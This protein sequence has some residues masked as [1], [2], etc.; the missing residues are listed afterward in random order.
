MKKP[1]QNITADYHQLKSISSILISSRLKT[2]V[3]TLACHGFIL[4]M[5]VCFNGLV[6]VNKAF[7]NKTQVTAISVGTQTGTATYGTAAPAITYVITLT[8]GTTGGTQANDAISIAWTSSTPAGVNAVFSSGASYNPASFT[9][10]TLTISTTASTLAGSYPFTITNID[11]NGGGTKTSTGTLTVGKKA[12]TITGV[13]AS[14]KV[15]DGNT[16]ATVSGTAT[17]NGAI[18]SDVVT[19]GGA[20]VGTF[21]SANVGSRTVTVTGY[22]ISGASAGNYTLTQPSLTANITAAPLTIT[23]STQSKTYGTTLTS[24]TG[25]TTFTSS[26]LIGGQTIGSVTITYG[27]GGTGTSAVGT[28]TGQATPSAATGGTFSASNYNITYVAGDLVVNAASLTITAAN[29]SMT[30]GSSI[31][32]LTAT[33]SGFVNGDTQATIVT[34]SATLSTSASSTSNVGTYSISTSGA[35]LNNSNYTISYVSG[36]LTITAAT[37]TVSADNQYKVQG[38]ANPTFTVSYSGFVNS[39]SQAS[40]VTTG[41]TVSTTA[42]TGSPAGSYA[43]TPSG[44]VL[45][46]SNYT[47]SYINGTLTIYAASYDWTGAAGT[48]D[49]TNPGNWAVSGITAT[50]YPGSGTADAVNI[51]VS[52]SYT[53]IANF[54]VLSS[55]LPNSIALLTIGSNGGASS[56]TITG[57]TLTV[58]GTMTVNS[59]ANFSVPGSGSLAIN[60]DF[61]NNGTI[62]FGSG[63]V[64]FGNNFYN[65]AGGVISFGTGLVTFSSTSG[66]SSGPTL[67]KSA[68]SSTNAPVTFV[69]LKLGDNGH[70]QFKSTIGTGNAA[71]FCLATNGI[72]TIGSSTVVNVS[73]SGFTL[74]SNANSSAAVD[75]IPSSSNLNGTF[76]VQRF[77]TGGNNS[78]YRCYRMLTSPVYTTTSG[79]SKILS[80]A[81]LNASATV[82]ATT[83][84]GAFTG[85][86]GTGF[87]VYNVNPTIYL[88]NESLAIDNAY[89]VSGKHVGIASITGNTV[90][91]ISNA[92]GT[93]VYTSGVSIPV[94][95]GYILYFVGPNTRTSGTSSIP[96]ADATLTATGSLNQGDVTVNLWYTPSGGTAGQLSYT[97]SLPGPGYNMVGNPYASTID[98]YSV[99]SYNYNSGTNSGID[100]IYTLSPT[101]PSQTY[102]VYTIAGSSSPSAYFAVSGQGFIVHATGTGQTLTFKEANKSP[103]KQ[104]TG[105]QLMMGTPVQGPSLTGLYLKLEKDSL[106]YDYTGIYFGNNWSDTFEIGDALYFNGNAI[107]IASFSSDGKMAA[108]NHLHTYTNDNRVR[109]YTSTQSDGAYTLKIEGIRNIDTTYDIYLVDHYKKDSVNIRKTGA[110]VFNIL[111]S[112]T[113]SFGGYR[114]ELAIHRNPAYAYQLLDFTAQQIAHSPHVLLTWKT[115]NELDN[116]FTVERSNDG[117]ATFTIAGGL[118]GTGAGLYSLTDK[119]AMDGQ[120]LY[121]LKSEDINNNVTYSQ[122][123]EVM[124]SGNGNAD[125]IRLYPNPATSAINLNVLGKTNG[126]ASYSITVSNSTG[127]IVK[128]ATS[129][130]PNWQASV[131]DL[132]PGTY[133]VR[134]VDNQTQSFVGESKFIK[135]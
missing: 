111:K 44:A 34:T 135:L 56:L 107:N 117:G 126:T 59:G 115:Q 61:T 26:G 31:P 121:R 49:W 2:G 38:S 9:T 55:T 12:L 24:A 27:T 81:Y 43:L 82:G 63:A 33:Y 104:L 13:T 120:N 131:S 84:Y 109:L 5:A 39:D 6:C 65:N 99:F 54:P 72:L 37:L 41:A 102:N 122:I 134:V 1:I 67:I 103:T 17:L 108:V 51:G 88:Y 19:L 132:L 89:Y 80:L 47:I 124:I 87:T 86:A 85:G 58:S 113:A 70:F 7:A 123:V 90:T 15:Y 22:T 30:Y 8:R 75:V 133:V 11:G 98:L 106:H 18:G 62:T 79:S 42:T 64:T 127:F 73:N 36:T 29:Q 94:G 21:S 69:N 57:T 3:K 83:Y 110:Y 35:V 53:S 93:V 74:L 92:T 105:G 129:S 48:S 77:I 112:D 128:Q 23:A 4:L 100:A 97:S 118:H 40:I 114:F 14:D 68:P 76:Y 71:V 45:N 91:T 78:M 20:P 28:Y 60:K 32:T 116:N 101:G 125:K 66:T 119:N 25:I 130:Q 50:S 16:T 10:I 96:P 95:N 52:A 46:T